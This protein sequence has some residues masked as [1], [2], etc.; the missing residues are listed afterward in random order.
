MLLSVLMLLAGMVLLFL[1]GDFLVKGAVGLAENLGIPALVIGLTV[2]AFGTSAPELFISVQAALAGQSGIAIG[3]VVGSNIANVL[4]V[5]GLPALIAPVTAN[6][7]GLRRNMT[8]M[9]ILTIVFMWL[10]ANGQIGRMEGLA[11][12]VSI[13]AF[14]AW[15]I[16]AGLAAGNGLAADL[17][18]EVGEAPH[19]RKRVTLYLLGGLVGL[20]LAAQLTIRGAVDIAEF[21][22]ISDAVIGLTVI[23]VGTSLPELATTLMAAIRRSGAVAIGNIVGSNIFNIAAIMGITAM[24]APVRVADRIIAIDMW[25]MLAT[26]VVLAVLAYARLSA[27]KLLGLLL[28]SSFG[29]Y[30]VSMAW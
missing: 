28:L 12:F 22:D 11:L 21:F 26:T 1:A 14:I 18:D 27:G 17:A 25:V 24:I 30:L 9:I 4:L 19:D 2:V 8:A 16:R 7:P 23:A 3:N 6:Q 13:C 15:Q 5:V 10:L 29:L 20:P